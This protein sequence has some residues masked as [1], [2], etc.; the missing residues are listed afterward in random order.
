MRGGSTDRT[1]TSLLKGTDFPDN[2][3]D[4]VDIDAEPGK[5]RYYNISKRHIIPLPQ[6]R[7]CPLTCPQ[8]LFPPRTIVLNKKNVLRW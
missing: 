1:K 2:E 3:E 6:W 7:A 8:A 5:G 4:N